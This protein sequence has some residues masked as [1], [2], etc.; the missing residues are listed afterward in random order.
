MRPPRHRCLHPPATWSRRHCGRR[1]V[2]RGSAPP[3]GPARTCRPVPARRGGGGPAPD[4]DPGVVAGRPSGTAAGP[5][6][7]HQRQAVRLWAGGLA[8]R[9]LDWAVAE[10]R[11]AA[12][13][14]AQL[15]RAADRSRS[16][17]RIAMVILDNLGIHT[18]KGSRLLR[19][20]LAELGE[21]LVL[22][23]TRPMTRT[24]TASS[25]CGGHCAAAS[26]TPTDA[27][28]WWTLSPTPT[29]GHARS[30]HPGAVADRQPIRARPAATRREGTRPCSMNSQEAFSVGDAHHQVAAGNL[31]GDPRSVSGPG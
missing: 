23:Y 10:G 18:P 1:V 16:R 25:G 22:V 21:Q 26:P 3:A 24:P 15:R 11:R 14:C 27:R 12:P 29:G 13:L 31:Q 19:E 2:P 8:R 6:A 7:R 5:G 9:H 4:P 17:G 30:P 20:L 28:R